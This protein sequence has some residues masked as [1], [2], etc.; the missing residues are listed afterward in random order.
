MLVE[1]KNISVPAK[2]VT[3]FGFGSENGPGLSRQSRSFIM[4]NTSEL[5]TLRIL[6]SH[7]GYA[8]VALM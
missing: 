6:A 4:Q 5:A 2:K 8:R 1:A 3:E 7:P